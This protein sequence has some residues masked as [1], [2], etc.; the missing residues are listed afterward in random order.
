[1]AIL[2]YIEVGPIEV[3]RMGVGASGRQLDTEM[4]EP[5]VDPVVGPNLAP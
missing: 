3:G 1:V 2:A 4:L 5:R